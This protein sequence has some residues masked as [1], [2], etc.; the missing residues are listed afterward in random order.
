MDE[1]LVCDLCGSAAHREVY[2]ATIRRSLDDSD[3]T[4][5]G[6]Q[7]EHPRIVRCTGCGLVYASPRDPVAELHAKYREIDVSSYLVEAESRR[8]TCEA[9]VASL[10]GYV[11]GGRVLDVGCSAGIFLSCLPA[12]F[13][14][15]GIEPGQHGVRHARMTIG[16][17][18]IHEGTDDTATFP[19]ANFD[20]VTMWDVIEHVPSPSATM[21]RLHRWVKP[22]GYAFLVTPDFGSPFA[23][24]LGRR[25]PHLIRQHL[26]YFDRRSATRLLTASGFDVVEI[27]TYSRRFKLGYIAK[28]AG[29]LPA[30]WEPAATGWS[31]AIS[32]VRVPVNVGDA[33]FIVAQRRPDA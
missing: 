19:A 22:G 29:L 20:A 24:I 3:F 26:Y 31:R 32:D 10:Q 11:S 6:E 33:L 18:A 15:Y 5:L 28:R 27:R 12:G 1:P 14:R 17:Q 8:I 30:H 13:Q 25:W 21:R 9:D 2:P 23:R 7:R 16:E 4:V